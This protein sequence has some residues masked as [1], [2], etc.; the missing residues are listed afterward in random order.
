M[1]WDFRDLSWEQK[2]LIAV[3]AIALVVL[4]YAYNPFAPQP[5]GN[6]TNDSTPYMAPQG[7]PFNTT[8]SNTT[9]NS[10]EGNFTISKLQAKEIAKENGYITGDPSK[11]TVNINNETISVWIVPL[12]KNNKVA[13]DV[14]VNS[15]S[16]I[17]VGTK[18][19]P[20]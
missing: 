12:Y 1:D 8:T 16:G 4:I 2:A 14:Y 19:Y 13:K 6:V 5:S 15:V 11:G 7:V 3:G 18:E 20:K 17:I 10:S 9:S